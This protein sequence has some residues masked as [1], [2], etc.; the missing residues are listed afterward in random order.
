V[1]DEYDTIWLSATDGPAKPLY[2]ITLV[3]PQASAQ[4]NQV[5]NPMTVSIDSSVSVEIGVSLTGDIPGTD[6][7]LEVGM[8]TTNETGTSGSFPVDLPKESEA[9][10][11]EGCIV[12]A[13][14]TYYGDG[15]KWGPS[16]EIATDNITEYNTAQPFADAEDMTNGTLAYDPLTTPY[17]PVT[18]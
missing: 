16:G 4:P 10:N 13:V 1:H 14:I 9:T 18:P 6:L 2:Q 3:G 7:G 8:S 5:L 15:E 17:S 12:G 11:W